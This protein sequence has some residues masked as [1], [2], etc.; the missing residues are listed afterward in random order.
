MNTRIGRVFGTS[1]GVALLAGTTLGGGAASARNAHA[2]NSI[3]L[4]LIQGTDF[5]HAM[6]SRVAEAQGYFTKQGLDV[7]IVGFSAGSD[8]VKA[9]QG[10]SVDIGAATGLDVAS[11]V[12]NGVDV[13]AFY[14]VETA[15]P[16]AVISK[17][18]TGISALKKLKNK[19]IGISRFG[20]FTDF[21]TKA[22]AKKDKLGT[23]VTEVPLGS[24]PANIAALESG[25]VDA[26]MLP[27]T[28]AYTL[29]EQDIDVRVVQ[30]SK[31]LKLQ[32]QFAVLMAS[33]SFLD[34]NAA[35]VKKFLKAYSEAIKFMQNKKH[36]TATLRVAAKQLSLATTPAK[37]TY[38]AIVKLFTPTGK[39][40]TKGLI[41]Y[42][43]AL[44]SLQLATSS[45]SLSQMYTSKFIPVK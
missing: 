25:Q 8:L 2:G 4:G 13:R 29:Q 19:K 10:G 6:P 21:L 33:P 5:T 7:K 9:M 32:E 44:P 24:P 39:I 11:A 22:I 28:F 1:L 30:V 43:K 40:N 36:A 16:M 23:S 17:K 20:S 15:D 3:T 35:S 38:N 27:V 37:K 26:I 41:A 12:A 42:S 18:A 14:G 45:P 31:E 34:G